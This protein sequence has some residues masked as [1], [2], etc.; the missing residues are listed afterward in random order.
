[1]A[2]TRVKTSKEQTPI[3]GSLNEAETRANDPDR[4]VF[5]WKG[6]RGLE[7]VE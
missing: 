4:E 1:M 3:F 7:R 6:K 5:P 2:F